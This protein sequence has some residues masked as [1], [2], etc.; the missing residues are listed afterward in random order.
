M[1]PQ[2]PTK[3]IYHSGRVIYRTGKNTYHPVR[4]R[5][6]AP[7]YDFFRETRLSRGK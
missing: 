5:N 3:T 2:R 7:L 6:G 1:S 4:A